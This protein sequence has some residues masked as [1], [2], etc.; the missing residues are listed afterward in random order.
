MLDSWAEIVEPSQTAALAAAL[1]AWCRKV[2][3]QNLDPRK[4]I[5]EYFHSRDEE[6]GYSTGDLRV[7]KKNDILIEEVG[8]IWSGNWRTIRKKQCRDRLGRLD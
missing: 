8:R 3:K 2:M 5:G 6:F 1:E 7:K 4:H